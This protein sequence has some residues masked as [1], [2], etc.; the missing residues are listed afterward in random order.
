MET[1]TG[2]YNTSVQSST[3]FTPFFLMFGRQAKLPMDVVYS[4]ALKDRLG[5]AYTMVREHMGSATGGQKEL[6]DAKVHGGEFKVGDLVWLHNPVVTQGASRKLPWAGPYQVVKKL[7]TVMFRIQDV[8][9]GRRSRKV[10]HFDRLKPCPSTVRFPPEHTTTKK[11]T[12]KQTAA[13]E[14]TD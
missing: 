1:G 4:T 7:S 11:Q 2:T 6:C 5:K 12:V 13:P 14:C 8:R 3:G 9:R 10:V